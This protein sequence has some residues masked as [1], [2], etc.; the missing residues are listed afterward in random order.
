MGVNPLFSERAFH[1]EKFKF[2]SQ[3]LIKEQ[4]LSLETKLKIVDLAYNANKE[5]KH[6]KLTKAEYI[7]LLNEIYNK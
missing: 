2:V 1:Y 7:K 6:R 5:G 4:P 3:I